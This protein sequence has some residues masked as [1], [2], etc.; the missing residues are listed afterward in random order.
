MLE[1]AD[2]SPSDDL[3]GRMVG[4][5]PAPLANTIEDPLEHFQF[6]RL[7]RCGNAGMVFDMHEASINDTG[8]ASNTPSR[9]IDRGGAGHDVRDGNV[10]SAGGPDNFR[11]SSCCQARG[12]R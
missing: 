2:Q 9:Q 12:K 11:K 8:S 5:H 1:K 7:Y 10:A 6:V 4:C 3:G